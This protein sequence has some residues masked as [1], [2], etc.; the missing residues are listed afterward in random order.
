M[1]LEELYLSHNGVEEIRGL[2]KNVKCVCVMY[3]VRM[4]CAVEPLN[5]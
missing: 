3:G 2:D 4:M 1:A 5:V